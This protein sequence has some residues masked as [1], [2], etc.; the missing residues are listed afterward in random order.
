MINEKN[1]FL[2][3]SWLS[4]LLSAEIFISTGE[5]GVQMPPLTSE[6]SYFLRSGP[7]GATL[8][9]SCLCRGP[10]YNIIFLYIYVTNIIWRTQT[11]IHVGFKTSM[12]F[13]GQIFINLETSFIRAF[14]HLPL[15]CPLWGSLC[16]HAGG[17]SVTTEACTSPLCGME[18]LK[19]IGA[20]L[21]CVQVT[22]D[23][24]GFWCPVYK[25]VCV[26]WLVRLMYRSCMAVTCTWSN[27]FP[28]LVAVLALFWDY[29]MWLYSASK[30]HCYGWAKNPRRQEYVKK[31]NT[32]HSPPNRADIAWAMVWVRLSIHTWILG[33]ETKE[34][35]GKT[36]NMFLYLKPL[37]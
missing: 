5:W 10:Q 9:M 20:I 1:N 33:P 12:G 16:K 19:L 25:S 11:K 4:G 34:L 35:V 14:L 26:Q 23:E 32:N 17:H 37:K 29:R 36:Q 28:S 8:V 7:Q 13:V 22:S 3:V 2:T 27:L 15:W 6:N 21:H 24:N 30:K 31:N 18:V